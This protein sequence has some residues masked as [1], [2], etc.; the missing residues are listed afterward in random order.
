MSSPPVFRP[1]VTLVVEDDHDVRRLVEIVLNERR[2][3]VLLASSGEEALAIIKDDPPDVV[4]LDWSLPGMDGL[5]VAAEIRSIASC[6]D[7]S[8]VLMTGRESPAD[9]VAA[10]NAGAND[11]LTKPFRLE[12]LYTRVLVAERHIRETRRRKGA[13]GHFRNLIEEVPEAISVVREDALVY[14]NASYVRMLR[15]ESAAELSGQPVRT[16]FHP[17]DLP[18]F[19]TWLDPPAN[20]QR[21]PPAECRLIAAD[22]SVV[23]VEMSCMQIDFDGAPALLTVARDVS[24]LRAMRARLLQADRM[25]TIGTLSAGVAHE[26]NNPLGYVITNL[27]VLYEML[28]PMRQILT[29]EQWEELVTTIRETRDGAERM[30]NIVRDLRTFARPE[31][32]QKSSVDVQRVLESCIKIAGTEIRYRARLDR[33]YEPVPFVEGNENRLGQVFL[34][35]IINAVQAM[36]DG[37]PEINTLQ[38]GTSL[39][40]QGSVCISIADTGKGI[41]AA[42]LAKIFD[43]FFTTKSSGNGLGLPIAQNIIRTLGGDIQVTSEVGRGTTFRVLLPPSVALTPKAIPQTMP[44]P[45]PQS[46]GPHGR[47]LIVDDEPLVASA[48]RRALK[49]HDVT[50]VSSGQD[51]IDVLA[52]GENFD[53][54]LCDLMM[55]DVSGLDVF[56]AVK[57]VRPDMKD[58][59]IFMTGGAFTPETRAF[60]E[61]VENERIEKPFDVHALRALVRSRTSQE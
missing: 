4:L 8:I 56:Q 18:I 43:P 51:A 52:S 25:A 10:L 7:A 16:V 46:T 39:D 17:D 26:L 50:S 61:H 15:Y 38:I 33:Q 5:S 31:D 59:F 37:G 22:G 28:E 45:P 57:L 30:R 42:D 53:V 24:E 13:E 49:E 2:H 55:P 21:P 3:R 27:R 34:N 41:S 20:A 60:L 6:E 48:L 40:E 11:Y 44:P 29:H 58:R 14:V 47:V 23:L 54:I 12:E 36:G 19:R 9:Q 35:L 32:E 1:V